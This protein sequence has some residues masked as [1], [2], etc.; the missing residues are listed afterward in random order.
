MEKD[1]YRV[2]LESNFDLEVSIPSDD[3][4]TEIHRIIYE[5]LVQGKVLDESR[6][7]IKLLI[8][9]HAEAGCQGIIAGCT[10]IELLVKPDDV[11]VPYFPTSALH[12]AAAAKFALA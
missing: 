4:R 8:A 10:E 5:E 9:H 11:G 1:F 12:A 6:D 3:D 2:N 7:Y